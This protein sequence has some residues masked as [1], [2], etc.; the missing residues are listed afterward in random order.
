[1]PTY[2]SRYNILR[3]M[4]YG[5]HVRFCDTLSFGIL[6][7]FTYR[8]TIQHQMFL[9]RVPGSERWNSHYSQSIIASLSSL[10]YV[11]VTSTCAGWHL[12]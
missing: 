2:G 6:L 9:F 5:I 11:R 10:V 4:T 7:P 8:Y 3:M 12:T 1:M